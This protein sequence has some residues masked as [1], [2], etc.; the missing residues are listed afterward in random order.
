MYTGFTK[1]C[2]ERMT[3]RNIS[4]EDITFVLEHGFFRNHPQN[5]VYRVEYGNLVVVVGYNCR[6]ITTFKINPADK[7]SSFGNASETKERGFRRK[8]EEL[9]IAEFNREIKYI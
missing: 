9:K 1:H 2:L 3:M 8:R 7:S 5:G 4:E 6:L